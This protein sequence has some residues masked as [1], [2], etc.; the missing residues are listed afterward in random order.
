MIDP[1]A[2]LSNTANSLQ[3]EVYNGKGK[4]GG[5]RAGYKPGEKAK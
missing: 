3:D 2:Q 5:D 1:L 4:V